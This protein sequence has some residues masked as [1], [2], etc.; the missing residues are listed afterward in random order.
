LI[1][2]IKARWL[3]NIEIKIEPVEAITDYAR[4]PISFQIKSILRVIPAD[5]GLGGIV[6]SEEKVEKPYYKDYD[7]HPGEGPESWPG[8]WDISGWEMLCAYSA[9]RRVGGA[10]VA[11]D[12]AGLNFL[13]GRKDMA[14]LW[15]IRVHPEFRGHGAGA[16]LFRRA[17]ECAKKRGCRFLKIETQNNNVSACRFYARQGCELVAIDRRAYAGLPDETQLIWCKAIE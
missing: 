6:L 10:L 3:M 15:D 7:A 2:F 11:Y 4:I 9:G 16:E 17:M 5:K 1:K 13:Q 12:T 14:A 8:R